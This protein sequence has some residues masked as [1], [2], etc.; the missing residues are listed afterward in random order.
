MRSVMRVALLAEGVD[1]NTQEVRQRCHDRVVALL[2]EG[3]DRN[4][5]GA[6][7]STRNS[8]ALL[9]EGVDRNKLFDAG[10]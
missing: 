1:R 9:A 4:L 2:A 7:L 10:I 6:R 5:T 3:V 8:V